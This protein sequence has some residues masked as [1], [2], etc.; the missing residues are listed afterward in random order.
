M[1]NDA[2]RGFAQ[3]GNL[4]LPCALTRNPSPKGRGERADVTS[5]IYLAARSDIKTSPGQDD[6]NAIAK[7]CRLNGLPACGHQCKHFA[8]HA[9][10]VV[11]IIFNAVR[12]EFLVLLQVL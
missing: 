8:F 3:V 6:F 10:T 5:I 9:W 2:R 4:D 11:R 7:G 1:D 12:A